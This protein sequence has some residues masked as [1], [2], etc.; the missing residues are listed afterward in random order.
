M[1]GGASLVLWAVMMA[2][3]GFRAKSWAVDHH[4]LNAGALA[5][6]LALVVNNPELM[7]LIGSPGTFGRGNCGYTLRIG[8]RV[9][10]PG[11]P[12]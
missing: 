1:L 10:L 5:T 8:S 9:A 2:A 11:Y 12:S 3:Q 6:T 4:F 7:I